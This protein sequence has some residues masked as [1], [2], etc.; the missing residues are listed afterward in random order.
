ML[1]A[2][3]NIKKS[4]SFPQNPNYIFVPFASL[5]YHH[6]KCIKTL[7][8][9]HYAVFP[10]ISIKGVQSFFRRAFQHLIKSQQLSFGWFIEWKLLPQMLSHYVHPH[11]GTGWDGNK[12]RE[13]S[14]NPGPSPYFPNSFAPG[15]ETSGSGSGSGC[16][17]D[18]CPTEFDFIT[19]EAPPVDSDRRE[20]E[21]SAAQ[22]GRSLQ[23]LIII[24]ISL[25]L[26]RQ[27]R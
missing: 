8:V 23:M 11:Q 16:T 13:N 10:L 1:P 19:T 21:A 22:P 18:I 2:S 15:D 5:V 27:W 9:F 4:Y 25:I 6:I 3:G 14:F 20:V 24:F 26:Q 7:R 12:E 17:D